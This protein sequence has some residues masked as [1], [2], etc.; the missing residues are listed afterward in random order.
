MIL[1][2]GSSLSFEIENVSSGFYGKKINKYV[3]CIFP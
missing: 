2:F 1:N 3:F